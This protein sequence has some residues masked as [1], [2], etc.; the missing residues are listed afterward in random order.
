M[1]TLKRELR[2]RDIVSLGINGVIGT[3]IF[4]LPGEAAAMLGPAATIPFLLSAVLCSLLVLCFAEAG[5]RFRGTGGPM[6]YAEAAFGS[7]VGFSVGWLMLIVRIITWGALAN[8]MV[9]ALEVVAP[10]AT[11]YRQGILCA[12]FGG[13]A[14]VN[15][16]GVRSSARVTNF[17]TMAKL[18]PMIAFVAIGIFFLDGS[19]YR[20]FAPHG[21]SAVGEGT[22][23][24]LFAFVG[25]ELLAVPAGEMKSPERHVPRALFTS[26]GIV[27]AI[28]LLIWVVCLG[29]LPALAGSESPVSDAAAIFMGPVGALVVSLGI[30]MSVLGVNLA[31]S[32]TAS[33]CL[34]GLSAEGHLPRIFGRAHAGTGAPVPA[35]LL[36]SALSLVVAL[37]GTYVELAVL[38]VIARFTQFIST[39]LA[40]LLLRGRSG[41]PPPFR[42]PF[43]PAIPVLALLLCGWLL[44]QAEPRQLFW[45][46]VAIAAGG[47]IYLGRRRS[48]V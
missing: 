14:A 38:S 10:G 25:F 13:I 33:R 17:F 34:Y 27:T 1:G 11:V 5:S 2:L 43:G 35:I 3:G 12:L 22:L 9:T 15:V 36:T 37:S 7:F 39:C 8:A 21:Y 32:I 24:I 44:S 47:V 46:V 4:F 19:L 42:A 41:E 16:T 48:S 30:L 28:Y 18:L 20:P 40:I 31:I 26:M 23:L 6:L 29:T 45:G